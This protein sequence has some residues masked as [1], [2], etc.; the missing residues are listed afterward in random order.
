[1]AGTAKKRPGKRGMAWSML[2]D[3]PRDPVTGKR[4]QKRFT[5][6]TKREL[7]TK[8][9]AFMNAVQTG[10]F[11]D[12]G[13]A[14][15]RDYVEQWLEAIAPSIRPST[16]RRYAD[17]VRLHVLPVLGEVRLARLSAAHLQRL[18]ADR[19]ATGLSPTTI[20][21]LHFMIHRALEQAVRW[22]LTARNVTD[23][24]DPPRR[25]TPD[26]KTWDSRQVVAFLAATKGDELEALWRLALMTGM[27][28]GEILGL[29]WED[30]D[31]GRG[32]LAVRRTCSRGRGG[33]W[34]FGA[35]KTAKG[36]RSIALPPSL[37]ES[38]RQ[39]RSA[40]VQRRLALG[41]AY[42]DQDLVFTNG[43]G[44]PVHPN[45]LAHRFRR[46]TAQAGLPAIRFHDLRHTS[47]TLMLA[48]GE[49]PKI[50]QER[51]GHADIGMTLN[52]YS[53]VT[54]DMQRQAAD[55]LDVLLDEAS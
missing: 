1:M 26:A 33:V 47:A 5:A 21:N 25:A 31:L 38:L 6:P 17:M 50:V 41:G 34:E 54:M 39:H 13:K 4:Q 10:T 24:V 44:D 3:G 52:L 45:S 51:L 48:N 23:A 46:L 19:L 18:Y 9:A 30:V 37:V 22:G 2:V 20:S 8:A 53:H 11:A 36:R 29:R 43:L 27:R 42:Q 35:P 15:V 12:P 40:H 32:V 49:H 16:H 7:E 28:R 14:T 55:R